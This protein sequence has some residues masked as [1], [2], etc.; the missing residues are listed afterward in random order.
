MTD[1]PVASVRAVSV[2]P[3]SAPEKV[4]VDEARVY[5]PGD[6]APTVRTASAAADTDANPPS[7]SIPSTVKVDADPVVVEL[8][9]S[10]Y[11][12][13]PV[14]TAAARTPAEELLIAVTTAD[15]EPSTGV[16]VTGAALPLVI[17]MLP[18]DET[19]APVCVT[20][21]ELTTP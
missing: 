21:P 11:E 3:G 1:T 20:V 15:S 14:L 19:V 9:C 12:P 17:V 6:P 13:S 8:S 4:F 7:P 16:M 10:L 5:W 18:V 2:T